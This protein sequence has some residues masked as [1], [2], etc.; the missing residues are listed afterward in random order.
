MASQP[1]VTAWRTKKLPMNADAI[2]KKNREW[3]RARRKLAVNG[4]RSKSG[5]FAKAIPPRFQSG[6]SEHLKDHRTD[7]QVMRGEVQNVQQRPPDD[8]RFDR[9]TLG[10]ANPQED[11]DRDTRGKLPQQ[12]ELAVPV[13]RFLG[14]VAREVA[15][16]EV[17]QRTPQELLR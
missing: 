8:H 3:S 10:C 2:A 16:T 17:I 12:P 15:A 6:P 11:R 5:A 7:D 13:I 9:E 4:G 14:K 1:T